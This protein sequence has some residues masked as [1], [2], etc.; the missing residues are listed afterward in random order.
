MP[1]VSGEEAWAYFDEARRHI[2]YG[3]AGPRPVIAHAKALFIQ[4][5]HNAEI[6]K[7]LN[8]QLDHQHE[9]PVLDGIDLE[10]PAIVG[11]PQAIRD[12]FTEGAL[13]GSFGLRKFAPPFDGDHLPSCGRSLLNNLGTEWARDDVSNPLEVRHDEPP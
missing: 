8:Q 3:N 4:V 6:W 7:I 2:E 10:S 1:L 13:R 11:D 5:T 9:C 12:V